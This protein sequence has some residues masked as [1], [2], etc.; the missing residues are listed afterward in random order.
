MRGHLLLPWVALMFAFGCHSFHP[1]PLPN[2]PKDATFLIVDGVRLHYTDEGQGPVVVLIHG[3]GSS[4]EIWH[5]VIP[6]LRGQHRV[7]A[8]DLKGF[9]WSSR[10]EGNYSPTEQARLVLLAMDALGVEKA[11]V[12]GHSWGASVSLALALQAPAR[13]H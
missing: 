11:D 4:L 1:G 6:A 13:V 3:F 9:G 7:V 2:A 5:Q 10:P 12:V 8:I